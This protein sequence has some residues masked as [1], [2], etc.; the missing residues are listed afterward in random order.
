MGAPTGVGDFF[1]ILEDDLSFRSLLRFIVPA[2]FGDL[3]DC[4]GYSGEL[5]FSWFRWPLPLRD[6]DCDV[7]IGI[8]R[9]RHLSGR[10]LGWWSKPGY[11]ALLKNMHTST[12]TIDKEYMSDL[13]VGF[14]FTSLMALPKS[15]SSGAQ[16]RIVQPRPEVEALTESMFFV[17]EQSPKSERWGLPSASMRIF[18]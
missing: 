5:K 2:P 11:A 8:F 18:G 14:C 10:K 16:Y 12:I 7:V 3:P 1:E 17:I 9:K 6:H 13:L 15:R 4:R